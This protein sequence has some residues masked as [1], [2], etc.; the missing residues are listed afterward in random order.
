MTPRSLALTLP[1]ALACASLVEARPR[2]VEV[3]ASLLNVREGP[4]T[5][6][7]ARGQLRRGQTY[8]LLEER[9]GWARLELGGRRLWASRTYLANSSQPLLEVSASELNVRSGPAL[10]FR[11]V[12]RVPRGTLLVER[13]RRGKWVEISFHGTTSW[14]HADHLRAPGATPQRPAR[15]RS[16]AGFIQLP[17]SGAGFS[18]YAR[19]S[20]RWGRPALIYALE[21]AARR[22]SRERPDRIGIGNISLARGGYFAPHTSHREGRDVDLAPVRTDRRELPTTVFQRV[23]DRRG[24]ARVLQLVRSEIPLRLVLFNDRRVPGVLYFP[25]HH[26]HM[27]LRIR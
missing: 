22:W 8:A 21:R 18:S 20:G 19:A 2:A 5:S 6:Y 23:Y 7:R 4:S 13:A 11:R 16:S 12:G 15:P 24:T 17:A 27:H 9:S 10:R 3:K 25:G 1:L 26:N 14:V